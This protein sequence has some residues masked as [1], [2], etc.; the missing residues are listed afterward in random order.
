MPRCKYQVR[1][2]TVGNLSG[3]IPVHLF[4]MEKESARCRNTERSRQEK[5]GKRM[6]SKNGAAFPPK[7]PRFYPN[8]G[9][10]A[11]PRVRDVAPCFGRLTA[12]AVHSEAYTADQRLQELRP[13]PEQPGLCKN[14]SPKGLLDSFSVP[15]ELSLF[16]PRRA[17]RRDCTVC[18]VPACP[19][20]VGPLS[21]VGGILRGS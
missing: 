8:P 15:F 2:A 13:V 19:R 14:P 21:G 9:W 5:E 3:I 20:N 11:L 18:R 1:F 17:L 16:Y 4:P 12:R 10:Y 6:E 7:R